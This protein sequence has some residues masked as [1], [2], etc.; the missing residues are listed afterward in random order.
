MTHSIKCSL[1]QQFHNSIVVTFCVGKTGA[2]ALAQLGFMAGSHVGR[3]SGRLAGR[4]ADEML[5]HLEIFKIICWMKHWKFI[6]I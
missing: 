5:L 2:T 3:L 6:R 4:L 1:Q